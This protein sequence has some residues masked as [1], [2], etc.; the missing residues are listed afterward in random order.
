MLCKC[1]FVECPNA[2][3]RYAECRYAECRNTPECQF[4]KN[5]FFFGA[6]PKISIEVRP[7]GA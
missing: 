5:F 6:I 1:N 2:K 4:Y 7:I 3:C